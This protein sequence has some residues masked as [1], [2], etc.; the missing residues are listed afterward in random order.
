MSANP[1]VS[2][3]IPCYNAELFVGKTIESVLRQSYS[4]IE[5][6]VIND[7]STDGSFQ[8]IK[9]YECQGVKLFDK[10][11]S[12]VSATRNMGLKISEG[13]YIHFLDSD[14]ILSPDFIEKAII[15]MENN[16][17]L[18]FCTFYIDQI[19]EEGNQLNN[20]SNHRGVYKEIQNEIVS[21]LPNVSA[22][23][24]AYVYRKSSL[25][26]NDIHF[27]EELQSPEDR[28][29]LLQVGRTLKGHLIPNSKLLY[30]VRQNSLSHSKTKALH[31]MQEKFYLNTIK[32]QLIIEEKDK[33]IFRKKMSRQ[34]AVTFFRLINFR[35]TLFYLFHYFN[36]I[37]I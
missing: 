13:K 3:I 19:D 2:V 9:S 20:D 23:P 35:K 14:D 5:I 1:L 31:L 34:L 25:I 17:E 15:E 28:H 10:A 22:C 24:S 18:D 33:V 37:K 16:Q 30:R 8:V 21:F 4:P 26:S 27:D 36:L 7:G 6:I 32:D 11:N 29:F 12:G